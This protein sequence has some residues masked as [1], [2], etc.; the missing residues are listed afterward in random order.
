MSMITCDQIRMARAALGWS[1]Q[2]LAKQSKSARTI[3]RIESEN[4]LSVVTP[5]NLKLI[6]T[7][8]EAAGVEFVGGPG[9]GPGVR[10]WGPGPTGVNISLC[11]QHKIGNLPN[12][13]CGGRAVPNDIDGVSYAEFTDPRRFL[14]RDESV[15]DYEFRLGQLLVDLSPA[16]S[17]ERRQ[18]ELI[19]QADLDIDRQRRIISVYLQPSK[20]TG[21]T[22]RAV[23]EW[24][25]D[26]SM[27]SQTATTGMVGRCRPQPE[28]VFGDFG[29]TP[30]IASA[31]GANLAM[32]DIP[33][34]R[35]VGGGAPPPDGDRLAAPAAGRRARRAVPDAQVI[36]G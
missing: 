21:P 22:H 30:A 11:L 9:D 13:N 15:E 5:A 26:T 19:T 27:R 23:V 25:H 24:R 33:L 8:L 17:L 1:F 18:V 4:G 14:L 29:A 6:I 28:P 34:P 3:K 32:L 35:P 2:T 12:I 36:G 7:T 20:V 16:N 10:L 31:Y